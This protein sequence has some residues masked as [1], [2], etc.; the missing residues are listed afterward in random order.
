LYP[1]M[2]PVLKRKKD[3]GRADALLIMH[4]GATQLGVL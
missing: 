1:S 3:I 4:Y 2:M